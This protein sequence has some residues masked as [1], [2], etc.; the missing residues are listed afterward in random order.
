[1]VIHFILYLLGIGY[2][3][4]L[5]NKDSFTWVTNLSQ[6]VNIPTYVALFGIDVTLIINHQ[7][8]AKNGE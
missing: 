4:I 3:L 5:V 8:N 1:M 7:R 2:G 6:G